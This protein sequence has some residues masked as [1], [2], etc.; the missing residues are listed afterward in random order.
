M[1]IPPFELERYFARYE[2]SARYLLS[3]SDCEAMAMQDLLDMADDSTRSLWEDLKLGY[4]ES[5][6][7]PLLR[8]AISGTYPGLHSD[9]TLVVT[10]EEGIFLAM[11][12]LLKPGDHV[13]ATFPGYQ[14]LYEIPRTIG[15]RMDFWKPAEGHEWQFELDRLEALLQPDTRLV[16][17][18]F[19]HNPTGALL[20]PDTFRSLVDLL[21]HRGIYLFSD[22]MYRHLEIEP[23]AILPAACEAYEK[24]VTLSGLSK[25]YGLPGLRIGWLASR[26][27]EFLARTARLKDYTTICNSAPSEVLGIIALANRQTIINRQQVRIRANLDVLETFMAAHGTI[28]RWRRPAGGSIGFPGFLRPEGA[29][30]FCERLVEQAGIM[31]LP[32]TPFQYGDKHVRIG[33]GRDNLPEVLQRLSDYLAGLSGYI[34]GPGGT[35]F[36]FPLEGGCSNHEKQ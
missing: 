18:N 7:H 35:G 8:Q 20:P 10:P 9:D 19:P 14:S 26:D 33:F 32:S 31:L 22:E 21:R 34:S 15:C 36:G 24:A 12:A 4:T 3:S 25:A 28:F 27:R 16:V 17:V 1:P 13:V 23:G 2:F 6:G 11:H 30:A 29:E 5:A